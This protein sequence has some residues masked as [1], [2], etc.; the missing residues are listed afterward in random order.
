MN[1]E[2]LCHK[3]ECASGADPV[4]KGVRLAAAVARGAEA[5]RIGFLADAFLGAAFLAIVFL[6]AAFLV[7]GFLATAFFL[8]AVFFAAAFLATG[9]TVEALDIALAV[10]VKAFW[11]APNAAVAAFNCFI[12]F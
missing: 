12:I 10:A 1:P 5:L 4:T 8:V 3:L 6:A 11:A 9:F 2:W 7:A